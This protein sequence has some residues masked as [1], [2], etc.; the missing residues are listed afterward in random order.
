[1]T[2]RTLTAT[3][4]L[5]YMIKQ[6][7][8][9][10][11]QTTNTATCHVSNTHTHTDARTHTQYQMSQTRLVII[12]VRKHNN[13][14]EM[15]S[16]LHHTANS[17]HES[18]FSFPWMLR[19]FLCICQLSIDL[20]TYRATCF[21]WVDLRAPASFPALRRQVSAWT[22]SCRE[23]FPGC[24]PQSG[25]PEYVSPSFLMCGVAGDLFSASFHLLCYSLREWICQPDG[26]PVFYLKKCGF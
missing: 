15:G 14:S 19:S 13:R 5:W 16:F 23:R 24:T 18:G 1:M 17:S 4:R 6:K 3:Q 2:E 22:F 8:L 26:L 21:L 9:S 25:E 20:G 11:F 12:A 10:C 7:A